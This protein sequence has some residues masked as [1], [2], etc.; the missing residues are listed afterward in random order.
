MVRRWGKT[1]CERA[2]QWVSL[3]LDDELSDFERAALERHLGG[4]A[5][6]QSLRIE[7][8]GLTQA[9]RATPPAPP[10][11]PIELPA[12]ARRPTLLR[13]GIGSLAL[14]AVLAAATVGAIVVT[15]QPPALGSSAFAF[16]NQ[17]ERLRYVRA[18]HLRVDPHVSTGESAVPLGP[19]PFEGFFQL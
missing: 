19:Y 3:E 4:C 17:R 8:V 11:M 6:C 12:P 14:A 5:A 1:A 7:L 10:R 15:E 2:A 18:E 9:L 13:R 16:A